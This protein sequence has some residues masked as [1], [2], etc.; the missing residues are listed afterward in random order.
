MREY[1]ISPKGSITLND[2]F[3]EEKYA[4]Y[5]CDSMIDDHRERQRRLR[6]LFEIDRLEALPWE[7]FLDEG[8]KKNPIMPDRD[9]R[10]IGSQKKASKIK[11]I[12]DLLD[13]NT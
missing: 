1:R 10:M 3:P 2:L 8:L 6:L 13:S 7:E 9:K 5:L 12:K 4:I 11:Q